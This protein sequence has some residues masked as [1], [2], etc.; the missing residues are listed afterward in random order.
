M[1]FLLKKKTK[2]QKKFMIL[3]QKLKIMKNS[4]NNLKKLKI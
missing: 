1:I 2:Y 4:K 3:N